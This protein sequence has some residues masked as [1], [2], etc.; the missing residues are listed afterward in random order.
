MSLTSFTALRHYFIVNVS[1]VPEVLLQMQAALFRWSCFLKA[2]SSQRSTERHVATVA[3]RRGFVQLSAAVI[4]NLKT[5][6]RLHQLLGTR[7]QPLIFFIY[8]Y[9]CNVTVMTVS[10]KIFIFHKTNVQFKPLFLSYKCSALFCASWLLLAK[11]YFYTFE[12]MKS[13]F[14]FLTQH[15]DFG[16]LCSL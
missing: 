2:V 13:N 1:D 10:F 7:S 8:W 14:H 3:L 9:L 12:W 11:K 16:H 6:T 15:A 4:S 5:L